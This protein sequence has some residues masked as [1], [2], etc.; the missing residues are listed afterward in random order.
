MIDREGNTGVFSKLKLRT[1]FHLIQINAQDVEKTVLTTRYG[2]FVYNVLEMRLRNA[3][4]T[5]NP[6]LNSIFRDLIDDI[7]L[8]YYSDLLIFNLN[9][10][11]HQQHPCLVLNRLKKNQ[12]YILFKKYPSMCQ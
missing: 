9:Q 7:Y 6:P 12:L 1:I 4:V 2:Q 3:P 5:S 11:E 10:E 8:T